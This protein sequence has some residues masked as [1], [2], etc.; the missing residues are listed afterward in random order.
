MPSLVW[1]EFDGNLVTLGD[2]SINL[3]TVTNAKGQRIDLG[4]SFVGGAR[5]SVKVKDSV[6]AGKYTLIYRVVSEDGHPV[7]GSLPF[8]YR[9]NR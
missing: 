6:P 1:I 2:K 5:I 4:N 9:P 7:Q 8:N 3:L